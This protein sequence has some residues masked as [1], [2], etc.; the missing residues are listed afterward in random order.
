MLK[1]LSAI[2]IAILAICGQAYSQF[3]NYLKDKVPPTPNAASL[4]KYGEIP[5]SKHTGTPEIKIP[6]Y[7][8]VAGDLSLPL[9]LSYHASGIRVNEV[10]SWV[11]LGWTFNAGGMISRTVMGE[12]DEGGTVLGDYGLH[13]VD[14]WY[15]SYGAVQLDGNSPES[16]RVDAHNRVI[17]SEPDMFFFN[18]SGV[19]GKFFFDEN[20]EAH[21]IPEQGVKITA[22]YDVNQQQ[23]LGFTI[24]IADGTQYI[25]GGNDAIERTAS[26]KPQFPNLTPVRN[27]A[28]Y[29]TEV[30]SA[31]TQ[32]VIHLD[33][34]REYYMFRNVGS[35][36][37]RNE[38]P[39]VCPVDVDFHSD[40]YQYDGHLNNTENQMVTEVEGL[41]LV[42]IESSSY[43]IDFEATDLRNDLDRWTSPLVIFPANNS[44][45]WFNHPPKRLNDI[46]VRGK[47]S[48]IL[49]KFALGCDYFESFF[50]PGGFPGDGSIDYN[51]NNNIQG[52]PDDY[53]LR[54]RYFAELSND[55]QDSL[56]HIFTYFE[57]DFPENGL[58]M[59]LPPR[60][61]FAQDDYGY[62][63]GEIFNNTLMPNLSLEGP[64]GNVVSCQYGADRSPK[65]PEML[66]GTLAK[67][68]YPTGG[69]SSFEFGPHQQQ[70]TIL[71]TREATGFLA[72][73]NGVTCGSS[74]LSGA[75]IGYPIPFNTY[76]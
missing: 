4:G 64:T 71:T 43:S 76:P 22:N 26:Y 32:D 21:V 69:I 65:F 9:S 19:S 38:G 74:N 37:Y 53:R 11:G 44:G 34:E 36:L 55:S 66:V 24:I 5:V 35:R 30:R 47:N 2:A 59:E 57:S 73:D 33:Y 15:E 48:D 39:G 40:V 62:F 45:A 28:W 52:N 14:G 8:F 18:F 23:F 31:T 3:D 68:I 27:A 10:S 42:R 7:D 70:K 60:K 13:L 63:N 61:T 75:F 67:I 49:K 46:V 25:F 56:K 72:N 16:D 58:S 20:R 50:Q 12:P 54:L 6:V 29:L 41:R 51:I 1:N 17:D